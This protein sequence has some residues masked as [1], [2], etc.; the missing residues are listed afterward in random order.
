MAT[1]GPVDAQA[2]RAAGTGGAIYTVNDIR[3]QRT[4]ELQAGRRLGA[5]RYERTYL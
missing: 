5:A 3:I 1:V 4:L 2:L